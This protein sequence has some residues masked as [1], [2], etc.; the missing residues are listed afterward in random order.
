MLV[1]AHRGASGSERENTWEAFRAAYE[2]RA[3]AIETDVRRCPFCKTLK[4]SHDPISSEQE[5]DTLMNFKDF[6]N[7]GEWMI[8]NVELKERGIAKEVAR[9]V[10]RLRHKDA[11]T[12]SS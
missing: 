11:I 12:Y 1:I 2:K 10:K 6:L 4:L 8:L 7:F 3:R 5:C 9:L